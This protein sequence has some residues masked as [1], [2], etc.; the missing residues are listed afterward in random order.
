MHVGEFTAKD[1]ARHFYN[2]GMTAR[3]ASTI[4]W[5]FAKGYVEQCPTAE[6]PAWASVP[7]PRECETREHPAKWRRVHKKGNKTRKQTAV[8]KMLA[9]RIGEPIALARTENVPAYDELPPTGAPPSG[10]ANTMAATSQDAHDGMSVDPQLLS[11][12]GPA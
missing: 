2:Y 7:A 12:M 3:M 8:P 9:K 5:D 1:I 10:D 4:F 11:P 6:E